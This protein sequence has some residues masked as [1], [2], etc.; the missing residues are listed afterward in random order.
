MSIAARVAG[1]IVGR[2]ARRAAPKIRAGVKRAWKYVKENPGTVGLGLFEGYRET[3]GGGST[4]EYPVKRARTKSRTVGADRK[5]AGMNTAGYGG[6]SYGRRQRSSVNKYDANGITAEYETTGE[7][8]SQNVNW[9]GCQSYV[10]T[11]SI[12]N[13]A[14]AIMRFIYRRY[15]GR[16]F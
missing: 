13:L 16:T 14:M 11:N 6:K 15:C 4:Q 7:V 10:L 8:E 12:P 1:R 9:I 5:N 2:Y 3:R